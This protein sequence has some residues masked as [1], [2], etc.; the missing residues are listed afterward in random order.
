MM[1]GMRLIVRTPPTESLI[2]L[3][4]AR[5]QC[6]VT[7]LGSPPAHPE[8]TLIESYIDAATR[9]LDGP[10]GWL[11]RALVEQGLELQL[12]TFPC[13][14]RVLRLPLPP[15]RAVTGIAYVD[16]D[17]AAQTLDP[18]SY[19]VIGGATGSPLVVTDE[20]PAYIEGAY[21]IEWPSVSPN[22]GAVVVSYTA[23]YGDAADVPQPIRNFVRHRVAQFYQHRESVI[24]G[25]IIAPVPFVADSLENFRVRA[26]R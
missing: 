8:D 9:E 18:A 6:R 24:S 10:R 14:G 2:T 21:G 5:L 4:D 1:P 3:E 22:M 11:G 25:T 19:R 26:D 7:A 23:G 15:L 13:W 17:G 20:E 16:S 12:D